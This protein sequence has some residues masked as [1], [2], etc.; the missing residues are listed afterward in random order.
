MAEMILHQPT[1]GDVPRVDEHG[2]EIAA[3]AKNPMKTIV[4]AA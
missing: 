1:I 2:E 4:R 3:K